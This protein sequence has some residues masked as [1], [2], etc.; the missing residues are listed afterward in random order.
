MINWREESL[1][2]NKNLD[3]WYPPLEV[4]NQDQYYA[5]AREVCHIC[6]VWESCL[7]DGKN[8]QWGMWGG[9]TPIE[10]SVYKSTPKKTAL[11]AHGTPIRYRQGCRCTSCESVHSMVIKEKKDLK[12]VPSSD[13]DINSGQVDFVTIL[14]RLLQ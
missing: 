8:E 7:N 6:P 12:Y 14:Y 2:V 5:I 13:I 9:L 1:C 10:R 3:F 11:K 4:S